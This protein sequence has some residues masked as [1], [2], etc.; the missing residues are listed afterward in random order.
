MTKT[1]GIVLYPEFED[2][3]AIGPKEVF[4][5][6]AMGSGGAWKVALVSQDGEPVKSFL[7]TRYIVDHSFETCPPLDVILLPG[8]MGTRAEMDNEK[9]LSF[10]RKHGKNAE[11]VTSVCTGSLI[12]HSAGFLTGK[13]ATTHWGSIEALRQLGSVTVLDDARWVQDGNVITAAG[14]S[15]GID[16]GLH[17]VS[18]LKDAQ[19]AKSVQHMMEYYPKPPTF[20]EVP[21]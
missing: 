12:L 18:L 2:L 1:I 9:M 19:T 10:V 6:F 3:D 7:G 17:L 14:V 4:G 16:M 5:M 11:Y 21:A 8:G 15:A 13:R 20:E